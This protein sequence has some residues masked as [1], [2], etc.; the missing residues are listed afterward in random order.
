MAPSRTICQ[1]SAEQDE[2]IIIAII[3]VKPPGYVKKAV[4][5]TLFYMD[6]AGGRED[7]I[8]MAISENDIHIF[9][10]DGSVTAGYATRPTPRSIISKAFIDMIYGLTTLRQI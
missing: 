2:D 10:L 9:D 6:K 5:E 1:F 3:E 8:G 7:V 4:T